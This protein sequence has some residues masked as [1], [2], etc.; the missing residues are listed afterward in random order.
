M[1]SKDTVNLIFKCGAL[2]PNH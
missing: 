1:T 2:E